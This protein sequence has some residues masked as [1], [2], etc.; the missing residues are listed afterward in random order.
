MYVYVYI[1]YACVFKYCICGGAR[2]CVCFCVHIC[3]QTSVWAVFL[4]SH[5]LSKIVLLLFVC[6]MSVWG[7]EDNSTASS[8]SL[9]VKLR[10]P[11]LHGKVSPTEPSFAPTVGI[12]SFF[13]RQGLSLKLTKD[14]GWSASKSPESASAAQ[15]WNYQHT[16]SLSKNLVLEIRFRPHVGVASTSSREPPL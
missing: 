11:H 3:V 2:V 7:L 9:E 4:R 14:T 13:L 12:L 8:L 1:C 16:W 15:R 6:M 10:S 5:S